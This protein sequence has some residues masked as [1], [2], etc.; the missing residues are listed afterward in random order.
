MGV[1][2][3]K[4]AAYIGD[5]NK[6]PDKGRERD[7]L[8]SKARRDLDWRKQFDLALFPEIENG[9]LRYANRNEGLLALIPPI[10][11]GVAMAAAGGWLFWR[12]GWPW[13]LLGSG[14]GIVIYALPAE[15]T[16][17]I[18]GN[19]AEVLMAL[20]LVLSAAHWLRQPRPQPGLSPAP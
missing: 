7:K 2:A 12:R 13:L 18:F 11:V 3:A 8:M 6:Y 15:M 5:M 14:A 4:V 1:K 10:L 9:T 17:M 19:A 20:G 16:G